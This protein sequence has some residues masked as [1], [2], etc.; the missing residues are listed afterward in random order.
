MRVVSPRWVIVTIAGKRLV[1]MCFGNPPIY[2]K[3]GVIGLFAYREPKTRRGR[4]LP[5]KYREA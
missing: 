4:R 5:C 1:L 3:G 2:I